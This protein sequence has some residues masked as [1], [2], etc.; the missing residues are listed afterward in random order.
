MMLPSSFGSVYTARATKLGAL[1][2][3]LP[4]GGGF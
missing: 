3:R 4:G 1:N 2:L